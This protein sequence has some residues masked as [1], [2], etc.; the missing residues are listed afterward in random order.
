METS[1]MKPRNLY[2]PLKYSIILH[3]QRI[4]VFR[5]CLMTKENFWRKCHQSQ[6]SIEIYLL[7]V[8][9][10]HRNANLENPQSLESLPK[11]VVKSYGSRSN[12][13]YLL[14]I[15]NPNFGHW[16]A[17]VTVTG[18]SCHSIPGLTKPTARAGVGAN[19]LLFAI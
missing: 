12:S 2:F 18:V 11:Q 9:T 14:S 3:S 5:L 17:P 8:N 7:G 6:N 15:W 19:Y 16:R 1:F 13:Q 4:T 10:L